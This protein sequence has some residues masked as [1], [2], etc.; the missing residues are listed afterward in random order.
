M[1]ILN[2]QKNKRQ[3]GVSMV[4]TMLVLP[5]ML[6]LGFGIVHGGLVFQARS[7][8]E[9]AALMAARVGASTSIDIEAMEEEVVKRMGASRAQSDIAPPLVQITVLNPTRAMFD[10]CGKLPSFPPNACADSPLDECEIPNFG[11]QFRAAC[12]GGVSI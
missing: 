4:E 2:K 5:I 7:N 3:R 6:M 1:I 9:Y 8:L 11:L 10:S 12:E